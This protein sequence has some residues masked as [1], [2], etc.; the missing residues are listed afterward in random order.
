MTTVPASADLPLAR[1][2][3]RQFGVSGHLRQVARGLDT[4][5][6]VITSD[7]RTLALRLAGSMPIRRVSAVRAEAAWIYD[8][9]RSAVIVPSVLPSPTGDRVV[10]VDDRDGVERGALLLTWLTGRRARKRVTVAHALGLGKLAAELHVHSR[11]FRLPA[12]TWLKTWDS[13]LMCGPRSARPALAQLVGRDTWTIAEAIETRLAQAGAALGDQGWGLI[14]ADIGPHNVVWS[15]GQPG[16]F[17]FNDSGWGYF[18]FDLARL[19]GGLRRRAAGDVLVER[20]LAGYESVAPLPEGW[21]EYGA[22]FELAAQMFL[23][24]FRAARLL[25]DDL[26]HA[27]A[28]RRMAAQVFDAVH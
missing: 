5:Y 25:P 1:E 3:L 18:S 2:A 23:A 13:S 10:V 19:A 15:H 24:H 12:D 16:L 17:D 9:A 26:E 28:L 14:N 7:G 8:L 20:L 6:R 11:Q 27:D 21:H 22:V 4:T